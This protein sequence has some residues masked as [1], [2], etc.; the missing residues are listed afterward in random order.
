[1][2]MKV[3]P[4]I[5]MVINAA[6][7]PENVRWSVMVFLLVL[8]LAGTLGSGKYPLVLFGR[9][10]DKFFKIIGEMALVREAGHTGRFDRRDSG[11]Q[12]LFCTVQADC[13]EIPV[14]GNPYLFCKGAQEIGFA[15]ICH[16]EQ[17]IQ[18]DISSKCSSI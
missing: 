11:F 2:D 4:Q 12:K 17:I 18:G 8:R 7:W 6:A 13:L 9:Q 1:M 14:R 3:V 10:T 15:E 16:G 5:N